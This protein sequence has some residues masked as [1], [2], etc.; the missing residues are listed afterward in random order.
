[1][2]KRRL[3]ATISSAAILLSIFCLLSTI[4]V[5][6][7]ADTQTVTE[8][9]TVVDQQRPKIG[10]VLSGGGAR[11]LAHIGILKV[12]EKNNIPIDYIVGTSMGSIIGGLYA[13]GLSPEEIELGVQGI[14]WDK[15]FSD[16]S[17]REYITFRRKHQ[18]LEFFNIR[19]IGITKNGLEISPGLIEGQL[20]ELALDRLAYPGFH[21]DN[22]DD[23]KIPYRAVASDLENGEPYIIDHGN[24]AKT[25]RA[26]MSIPGV[27][28]PITIDNKLLIDGG[29]GNNIPIDVARSLGADIVIVV[30]VSAP[31]EEKEKIK[32]ALDITA[33]LTNILTRRIADYQLNTLTDR[34]ILIT[35]AISEYSSA[36][37]ILYNE[38]IDAGTTAANE[39]IEQLKKLSLNDERYTDYLSQHPDIALRN[40]VIDYIVIKN[41]SLLAD[42]AL[43]HRIRQEIGEPLDVLQLEEDL[44]IIYGLDH[45]SSVVYSLDTKDGKTGLIVYIRGRNWA[46][47]YLEFGLQLGSETE[48]GSSAN[49]D[50][51]YTNVNINK[52][53]AEFRAAAGL[54][55]EP[56]AS[57]EF[58]QP[59]GYEMDYF[60]SAKTGIKTEI[61]PVIRNEN[62]EAF[63]RF[64]RRFI[65]LSTG[66][67][68]GQ[69][70]QLRLDLFHRVGTTRPVTG[71]VA[72]SSSDFDEG[73]YN[74][75]LIH[76]SLDNISFPNSGLFG[77]INYIK[78]TES[79]GA[80]SNY[81]QAKF[82]FGGAG[83]YKRYTFFSRVMFETTLNE[84][85]PGNAVFRRGG[86]LELSGH[87]DKQL[88]GQHFGLIEAAFYRRLGDI[89]FLPIY[90]GFS[91]EN[92]NAW[93]ST[94]EISPDN[95]LFAGSAFIGADTF[96][97]PIYVAFGLS[98]NGEKALY[99][100]LGKSFLK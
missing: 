79:F 44:S 33:Q 87:Y 42:N 56:K 86:F 9:N 95:F 81:Q 23:L 14:A 34:D 11:G 30:D 92:G 19:R 22:Y 88:V 38:L 52:F 61:F 75:G 59:L 57:I 47:S 45:S 97:G 65:K 53:G 99:F 21:I 83:T 96:M 20:I 8:T 41:E 66:K 12:L 29:I 51:T 54:G 100:S 69:N 77:N 35:P 89:S 85:A 74:I 6:A 58:H 18:D 78:N 4:P 25:M 73:G 13:I 76:D 26:S 2:T 68:F 71:S 60:I 72:V 46:P 50:A 39:S 94:S 10:L 32:S 84:N 15:V 62:V 28:P 27:L 24:L 93:N 36:D 90:A 37:F 31:L 64:E 91:I 40:P 98:E 82:S 1:M 49:I 80:T 48:I 5:Y 17:S 3:P 70:T 43:S 67:T 63:H 16:V 7:E 55:H